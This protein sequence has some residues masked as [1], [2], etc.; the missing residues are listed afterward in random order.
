MAISIFVPLGA[1]LDL[2]EPGD[3]VALGMAEPEGE[4]PKK[5]TIRAVDY[6]TV[7]AEALNTMIS[8]LADRSAAREKAV[9]RFQGLID[10]L[11]EQRVDEATILALKAVLGELSGSR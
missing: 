11:A 5:V 3:P 8:A 10:E 7:E 2:L 4:V 9:D 6:L 1:Q